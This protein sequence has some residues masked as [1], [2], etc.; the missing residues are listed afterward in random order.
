MLFRSGGL[1]Q[2]L[3]GLAKQR[4]VTVVQGSAR[5]TGAHQLAV[6]GANDSQTLEFEQAIIAAGSEPVRLPGLPYEDPRI[7]D[8]TGALALEDIPGRLLVVGGGAG[9]AIG[10]HGTR[11][12]MA[13]AG[14]P[15]RAQTGDESRLPSARA[16]GDK[17]RSSKMRN[18]LDDGQDRPL[19]PAQH[20]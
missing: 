16:L 18:A 14:N 6:D 9:F 3:S 20:A 8:S 7:I 1:T 5:F 10:A 19:L 15:H 2:G 11:F 12:K 17:G 4:K 13:C